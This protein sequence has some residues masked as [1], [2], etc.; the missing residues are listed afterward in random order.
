MDSYAT[1]FG[2]ILALKATRDIEANEEI[3]WNYNYKVPFAPVWYRDCWFL[4]VRGDLGWGEARVQNYCRDALRRWVGRW[5]SVQV[6][7]SDS[8][9]APW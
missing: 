5:G 1:R 2:S 4:H 6:G 3:S 9:P 7:E 8:V